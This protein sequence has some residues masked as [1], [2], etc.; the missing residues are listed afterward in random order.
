[1]I[2]IKIGII[3][4]IHSNIEALNII[5]TEFDKLKVNKIIC[6]GDIIGIGIN[7]NEVVE[8]LIKYK[9]KLVC[10]LGNHE[11]YLLNGIP[12]YVHGTKKMSTLE[13][14]NHKYNHSM[15][16]KKSIEFLRSLNSEEIININNT[17]IYI[18]HYPI[19]QKGN[20]YNITEDNQIDKIFSNKI[21]DIFIYGH[22]HKYSMNKI[23]NKI[24]LNPGSLGCPKD[25]N[26][27]SSCILNI[28]DKI[29]VEKIEIEYDTTNIINQI[30]KIKMP[31]YD[32]ILK[33]FYNQ[34][35]R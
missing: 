28:D 13:I 25:K 35:K 31:F 14:E 22:T 1:M 29:L 19:N 32:K 12:K 16:S 9:D 30:N 21:S 23:N 33:I 26:L 5:L 34:N 10:V 11:K 20:Y 15:L 24:Y 4:D 8:K 17:K 3:S 2:N 6:C 27:L 7:P 18:T